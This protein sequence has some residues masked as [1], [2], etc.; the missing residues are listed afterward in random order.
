MTL[1]THA[2]VVRQ[3]YKALLHGEAVVAPPPVILE[4]GGDAPNEDEDIPEGFF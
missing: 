3:V 1:L 2:T 4:F